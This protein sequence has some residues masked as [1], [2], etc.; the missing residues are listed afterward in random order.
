MRGGKEKFLAEAQ[1]GGGQGEEGRA[2][3]ESVQR[4]RFAKSAMLAIIVGAFALQACSMPSAPTDRYAIVIGIK[5]YPGNLNDLYYTVNDANSMASYLTQSGWTVTN[6]LT[7]SAATRSAIQ[8]AIAA[9]LSRVSSNSSIL[10]YYSGHGSISYDNTTAYMIPWDGL[11]SSNGFDVGRWITPAD[12]DGWMTSVPCTNRILILDSC[13]SGGFVDDSISSDAA[14]ANYGP[15]DGG[16]TAGTLS[17]AFSEASGLLA[18]AFS[19][20]SDPAILTISAAGAQEL[21]YDDGG[22]LHGAFTYWLLKAFTDSAADSDGNRLVT[23]TEA[24]AYAK[25]ELL[26][27][28]D[29]INYDVPNASY[30]YTPVVDPT[31]GKVIMADFLPRISGGSGDIVLYDKR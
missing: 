14:P 11:T 24:Y 8:S 21:S 5:D 19:A 10:V 26:A 2:R 16:I 1:K 29:A 4:K 30:P 9:L 20:M 31:T 18:N 3:M 23:A 27:N 22:T 12:I 13:Y 25:N 17:V 6:T 15:N 7:D 28:W